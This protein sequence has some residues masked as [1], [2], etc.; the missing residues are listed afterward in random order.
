MINGLKKIMLALAG[1]FCLAPIYGTSFTGRVLDAATLQPLAG[2]AVIV[3]NTA[4]GGNTDSEGNFILQTDAPLPVTLSVSLLG[5]LPQE[6][7]VG[8]AD[9]SITVLLVE[10]VRY[11]NEVVV[12]GYGTQRRKELTGAVASVPK[13]VLEHA[14]VSLDRLLGGA[15]AGVSV[16]QVSGQPGAG[17]SV[18]I[19]GGNSINANNDPLYVIDGFIFY[20]DN[21]VNRAGLNHIESTLNPL[22]A[23]NPADIE[24]VEVLKDVSATAIYGSRGANGVIIVTTKKGTR[25]G[26]RVNYQY[27]IGWDK[28]AKKLGLLNASQ[29]ARMQKDFFLNKGKYTDEEIAQLGEGYDWQGAVLQTG[30]TQTHELSLSGGDDHMR[31]LLSGNYTGQDGIVLHS[32]FRRYNARVNIDKNLGNR[33]TAGVTATAGK[34]VQNSLTAFQEVNYNSSPYSAGITNSLVYALYIPPVVPVYTATGD[35]NYDNPFEYSYLIYDGKTA[36][37]VSDLKNSTGETIGLSLLG[38]AYVRYA[39][40]DGLVAKVNAG[41]YI[42]HATQ[43]FFAPSYTAIGLETFG[44]GGIGNKRQE[45]WQAEFTLAFTKQLNESHFID[46]LAGYTYQDTQTRFNTSLTSDFT[47]E[48]LGVNNLA[49]GAHPFSPVSGASEARL[50]SLLARV[51]YTLLGRYHLTATIRNDKST[52]FAKNH[53]WG[54][55]PS[56]GFSWNINEEPFLENRRAWSALKL[57][58]TYGTVGNQ[59][60]GD[61]EYAQSFTASRANGGIAYSQTNLGNKNLKWETTTQYNAGIDAAWLDGRLSVTAD[62]YY[63]KTFDLLLEIPVDPLLGVA[64]QLVNVG[65]VTNRGV[66]FSINLLAIDRPRFRWTIAANISRNRNKIT[67]M[68]EYRQLVLGRNEEEILQVGESLGAFYGLVFD[69]IVQKDEDVSAL[70]KTVHGAAQPGDLK[71]ADLSGPQG[72]PDNEINSYDRAHLG[73]IQPAYTCGLQTT[74]DW[75]GFDLFISLQGA[76]GNKVYNHLRRHL[77]LPNDSY[78]AS[79]ALLDSWTQT[80]PSNTLPGIAN[81]ANDRY[82]SYLDSRYV[83]DASFLR[84]KNITLGYTLAPLKTRKN[85]SLRIY[86]AAQNL[87]VLSPYNGYDPE[88][89]RGIDLGA[90]P[91]ARTFIIGANINF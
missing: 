35:Y 23:I 70:P 27:S 33:F 76:Q 31:Y 34:S 24:S 9:K 82:Y 57:R 85:I 51:N 83:E 40:V 2:A 12:V 48:T 81:I 7:A 86:A 29:W 63:K 20:G 1:G 90:Y 87:F 30:I 16:S 38:N 14:A 25:G 8:E 5:Y 50:H 74:I 4:V 19:R 53:R 10:N 78:N 88:V 69:G 58:L 3:K 42:N 71:F 84:L 75:R 65:N 18:R 28:P 54:A 79:A 60:I 49:D 72:V 89:A 67:D 32:G 17:S 22:A 56:I 68:G 41:T 26:N 61:Y 36:N 77:E 43:H 80:R 37:P 52:R 55:F 15:V 39:I 66:E 11:L 13:S 45:V 6:V 46:V 44:L 62:L 21:T 64:S 73:S 59:E 91:T 47:N